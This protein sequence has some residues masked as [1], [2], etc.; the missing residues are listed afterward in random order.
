MYL[1]ESAVREILEEG[2]LLCSQL[3]TPSY[4]EQHKWDVQRGTSLFYI[5]V[6]RVRRMV[7]VMA[8][9]PD[10]GCSFLTDNG[11]SF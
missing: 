5:M 10:N 9:P 6:V 2:A 3:G 1:G 11:C 7:R 4:L 8:A